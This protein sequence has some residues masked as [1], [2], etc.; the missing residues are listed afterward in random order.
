MAKAKATGPILDRWIGWKVAM[1]NTSNNTAV[2]ME[3][4]LDS[5]NTNHWTKVTNLTDNGGWYAD[6]SDKRFY[7]AKCGKP[8]DYIITNSGPVATFRWDNMIWDFADLSVREIQPTVT[9]S[10]PN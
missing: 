6:T 9:Q 1:Y 3:S 2:K 10:S 8:K 4:Y 7:S 5:N